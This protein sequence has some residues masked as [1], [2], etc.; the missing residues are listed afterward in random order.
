[1]LQASNELL[2]CMQQRWMEGR[3]SSL[4]YLQF[5]NAAAG[6]STSNFSAYPVFPWVLERSACTTNS[7][8]PEFLLQAAA[9]T[10]AAAAAVAAAVAAGCTLSLDVLL[11]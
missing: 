5:L 10:I 11:P 2:R 4:H 7:L 8:L 1:M 3:V 6:R 9:A